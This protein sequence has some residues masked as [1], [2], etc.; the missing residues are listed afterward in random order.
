MPQRFYVA[1]CLLMSSIQDSF[2]GQQERSSNN[3]NWS[4]T[5][6]YYSLV[7]GGRLLC[8]LALGDYPT[9]HA[10]LRRVFSPLSRPRPEQRPRRDGYPFDWL[11]GFAAL[12]GP[13]SEQSHPE[14]GGAGTA[15]REMITSYLNAVHVAQVE[16]R[17]TKFGRVLGAAAP[18]RND[19]NYEALLIAHEYQH[20]TMSTA[21]ERLSGHMSNAAEATLPFLVDAFNGFRSHD[22]GLL[23]DRDE[24]ESFLHEY[25]HVRI[26]SA[27][28][29]KIADS[30]T[31]GERLQE[32]LARL[33]TRR[34]GVRFDHL[35][36]QVSMAVFGGKAQLMRQFE[37]RIADLERE[38]IGDGDPV[39]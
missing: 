28:Q 16:P 25:V 18:L 4:A 34:T 27:I 21:F 6:S 8:F 30:P 35:E 7:H 10:E 29:H 14:E 23:R 11:R 5:L 15:W 19:S 20:V 33:E 31:L 13:R 2:L 1:F 32:I 3:L 12:T 26:G 24:Y 38:T 9:T 36:D 17:L 39:I 37:E 22:P